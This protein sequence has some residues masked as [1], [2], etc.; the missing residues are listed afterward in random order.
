LES[1]KNLFTWDK[2]KF[3]PILL[4]IGI[5]P[6]TVRLKTVHMEGLEKD[7]LP[8]PFV[9]SDIFNYYKAE[10]IFYSALLAI[11]FLIA[12]WVLGKTKYKMS[13]IDKIAL[14][15]GAVVIV[16]SILSP[17][18]EVVWRGYAER[19]HGARTWLSYIVMYFYF[20]I[21]IRDFQSRLDVTRIVLF[22]GLIMG[23]IGVFQLLGLDPLKAEIVKRMILP[24]DYVSQFGT[25]GI[26]F[27]FEDTRVYLTLYNP[28]NVG[29]YA[30][31]M[32]PF[33]VYGWMNEKS[34]MFKGL[35]SLFG[36]QLI[37]ALVGSYSRA[38]IVAIVI[39]FGV[40]MVFNLSVFVLNGKK[41]VVGLVVLL[42]VALLGNQLSGQILTR[43]LGDVFNSRALYTKVEAVDVQGKVLLVNYNNQEVYFEYIQTPDGLVP[44]I[45][46]AQESELD[47]I[48]NEEGD[49]V[50]NN[51]QLA[52]L[53]FRYISYTDIG[54]VVELVSGQIKWPFAMTDEGYKYVNAFGKLVNVE[55]SQSIG[56]E[57]KERLGSNR[58]YIWSRSL[59]L[60]KESPIFG[61]GADSFTLS[62]PQNDYINQGNVFGDTQKI[63]DKPH[64]QF[65]GLFIEFGLIGLGLFLA[66]FVGSVFTYRKDILS[67]SVLGIMI[68]FMFYDISVG[69]GWILIMTF[70]ILTTDTI[71]EVS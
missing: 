13:I 53:K 70:G 55:A 57:G 35:W 8:T 7:W 39:A 21:V 36:V 32:L 17:Y 27:T 60:I 44:T 14:A 64:N 18:K 9:Y 15:F 50:F 66:W 30:A 46:D 45:Y 5:M 22:S 41:M 58:G 67:V 28:N 20:R 3:I 62:F 48:E 51:E 49:F 61:S 1:F 71:Q 37:L 29:L 43:R 54:I 24:L 65:I 47:V 68:S 42:L 56:F 63:V 34:V 31:A 23:S 6:L 10:L 59:L 25:E 16:S 69:T 11:A 12:G 40:Y 26:S 38:G 4:F 33:C 2:L 19:W 52:G